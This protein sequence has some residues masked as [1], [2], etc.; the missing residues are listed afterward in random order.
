MTVFSHESFPIAVTA[1]THLRDFLARQK[2][3]PNRRPFRPYNPAPAQR[4]VTTITDSCDSG[5]Y[6]HNRARN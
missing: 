1:V 3:C 5:L 6:T 4:A 2:R